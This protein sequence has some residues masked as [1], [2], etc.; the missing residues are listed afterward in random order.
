MLLHAC[1][2]LLSRCSR[3]N[4]GIRTTSLSNQKVGSCSSRVDFGPWEE[5]GLRSHFPLEEIFQNAQLNSCTRELTGKLCRPQSIFAVL[6]L[7]ILTSVLYKVVLFVTSSDTISNLQKTEVHFTNFCENPIYH[8]KSEGLN[9]QNFSQSNL[10]KFWK[11]NLQ[12]DIL[13]NKSRKNLQIRWG[14]GA[15][16]KNLKVKSAK[17]RKVKSVKSRPRG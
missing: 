13:G 7:T 11:F 8:K 1:N 16:C 2:H 9:L 4:S 3:E 12:N 6:K 15:Q 5:I 14:G 10:H 17:F